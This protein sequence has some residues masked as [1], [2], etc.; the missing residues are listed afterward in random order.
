MPSLTREVRI[1]MP[2][3]LV[4]PVYDMVAV[5]ILIV[6]GFVCAKKG[7]ARGVLDFLAYILSL[8][9][10]Y[11]LSKVGALF[12]YEVM[13]KKNMV[14]MMEKALN[15]VEESAGLDSVLEQLPDFLNKLME[16]AGTKLQTDDLL[17]E[18]IAAAASAIEAQVIGPAVVLFIQI[19]LMLVSFGVLFFFA[20]RL[21][22]MIAKLFD[23]PLIGTMN[24]MAGFILG[25]L[26]GL[27]VLYV[28]TMALKL[29]VAVTGGFPPY[30]TRE[31]LDST[32][33]SRLMALIGEIFTGLFLKE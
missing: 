5:T 29:V 21:A 24:H 15:S 9:G 20:K 7:F 8:V 3:D 27:I 25:I 12:I 22:R 11:V 17:G 33:M 28:L 19:I 2:A 10:A 23:L 1:P 31:V 30:L 14:S 13:I 4:I 6:V 16:F 32:L 18:T 26:E